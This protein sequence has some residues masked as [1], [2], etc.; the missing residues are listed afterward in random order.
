MIRTPAAFSALPPGAL[1]VPEG[2]KYLGVSEPTAW[3]MLRDGTLPRIKLRGRTVVRRADC[4]ALLARLSKESF[5]SPA[6]A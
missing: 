4:D 3:R 2:A 6:E 1:R 5:C